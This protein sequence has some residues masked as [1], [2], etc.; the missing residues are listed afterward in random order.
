MSWGVHGSDTYTNSLLLLQSDL[1]TAC[2]LAVHSDAVGSR[3]A[4]YD[5]MSQTVTRNGWS[6][7]STQSVGMWHEVTFL[8]LTAQ[9]EI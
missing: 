9:V 4:L 7:L 2:L 8:K 1:V 6:L 3:Q 5:T